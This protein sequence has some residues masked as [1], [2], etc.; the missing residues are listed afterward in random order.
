[1]KRLERFVLL[2]G[3]VFLIA[4]G[5]AA[6]PSALAQ[7]SLT[8]RESRGKQIYVQGTSPSAREILAY[9]G[10]SSLEIPGTSMACA[11]CH[12]LDGQGKPEGGINPSDIRSEFLT[13]PYGVTHPDGRKHPPYTEHG[14]ELA[15]TR[16]TDPAGNRL[17]S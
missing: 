7:E 10:E 13:K 11:N 1:M 17:L 9:V 16:G 14:L 4:L 12:G 2:A 3:L 8:P 6:W 15:I 5:A